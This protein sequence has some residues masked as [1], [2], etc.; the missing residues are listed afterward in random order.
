MHFTIKNAHNLRFIEV[1][2][3]KLPFY[4]VCGNKKYFFIGTD[5]FV[6]NTIDGVAM[7]FHTICECEKREIF[8]LLSTRY[9]KD[10]Y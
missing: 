3:W 7:T 4:K 5:S 10:I 9:V 8:A 6:L 2:S 1:V